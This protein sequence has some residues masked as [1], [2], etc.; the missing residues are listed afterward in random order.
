MRLNSKTEVEESHERGGF[1][2]LR[3][4]VRMRVFRDSVMLLFAAN[5]PLTLTLRER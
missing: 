3:E 4:K 1:F 2:S 5:K